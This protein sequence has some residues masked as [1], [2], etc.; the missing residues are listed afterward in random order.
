MFQVKVN[1][2][3]LLEQIKTEFK[4]TIKCNKYR[5]QMTVQPQKNNLIIQLIQHLQMLMDYLFCR[6][7]ELLE[8][9]I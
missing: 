8:K 2:I 7:K 6:F 3:K 9:I 4:R 1:D 5:S